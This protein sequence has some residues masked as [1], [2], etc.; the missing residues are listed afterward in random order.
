MTYNIS[1]SESKVKNMEEF[2]AKKGK[3]AELTG[4]I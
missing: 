1:V 2:M 4:P 3:R